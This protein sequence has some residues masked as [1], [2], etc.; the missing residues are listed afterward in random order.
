MN[1]RTVKSPSGAP[2][3]LA[4]RAPLRTWAG[5]GTGQKCHLCGRP[6]ESGE[7]E[8]EVE[9]AGKRLHFHFR[10][11]QAWE[12]QQLSAPKMSP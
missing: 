9:N 7:I 5:Q 4:A 8:Y 2:R 11:Q 3:G 6:I 1:S 10:C 12:E